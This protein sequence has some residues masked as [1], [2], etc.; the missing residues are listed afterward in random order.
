M[1]YGGSQS[2]LFDALAAGRPILCNAKFGYNLITRYNCGVVTDE[3]TPEAFKKAVL[4][5]YNMPKSELDQMGKNGRKAAIDY[6]I[7]VLVDKFI[8]VLDYLDKKGE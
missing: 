6:D 3:Q 8:G 4:E 1:K 7:P 2:K 5:L